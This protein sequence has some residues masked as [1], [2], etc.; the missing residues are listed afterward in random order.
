MSLSPLGND[1]ANVRLAALGMRAGDLRVLLR[2]QLIG[3]LASAIAVLA[4]AGMVAAGAPYGQTAGLA[5]RVAALQ[6]VD[7]A[8]GQ[9]S[10]DEVPAM[11]RHFVP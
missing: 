5:E 1:L 3:S 8:R 9:V 11:F 7:L 2:Q 4:I 10:P 6:N